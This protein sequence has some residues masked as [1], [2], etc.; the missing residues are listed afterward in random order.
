MTAKKLRVY[1]AS[2]LTEAPLCRN[3]ARDWREIEFTARWPFVHYPDDVPAICSIGWE[4][5]LEDIARSDVV[6][7][8]AASAEEKLRGALVEA[9]MG[10]ALGKRIIVVGDHPDYGSWQFHP[11]VYHAETLAEAR[12]LLSCMGT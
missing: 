1:T 8:F 10:I 11:L 2:K 3:L 5:D 12:V 4:Q 7:V 9:G 6:L